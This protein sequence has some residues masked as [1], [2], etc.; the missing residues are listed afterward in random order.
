MKNIKTYFWLGEPNFGDNLNNIILPKLFNVV[1]ILTKPSDCEMS[2]IGSLMDDFLQ[3]GKRNIEFYKN[4]YLNKEVN[5]WGS[6]FIASPDDKFYKQN[7]YKEN[8][9]RKLIFNA[10]RGNIT[11]KRIEK[12]L[13]KELDNIVLGDP[14]I[15]ANRL[16]DLSKIEKK[17]SVGIIPHHVE[18]NMKIFKEIQE[19]YSNSIL[20][21]ILEDPYLIMEKIASCEIIL[22]SAMHGLIVSDSFNIPNRRII[23]SDLL[24][25]GDYKFEDYYS[26]FNISKTNFIVLNKDKIDL[27]EIKSD[28]QINHHQLQKMGEELIKVFPFKNN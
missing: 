17:Y 10:V 7:R 3:V 24:I 12:I 1:P 25:G 8:F 13:N 4:K 2:G 14:G 26:A 11:K 27:K 19:N 15:L 16:I 18:V 23:A 6:G 21:N 5:V 20:I 28:Y 9:N 22:S